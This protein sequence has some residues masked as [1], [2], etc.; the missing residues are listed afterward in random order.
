METETQLRPLLEQ[1]DLQI[2]LIQGDR[3]H[4]DHDDRGDDGSG[5]AFS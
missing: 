5:C 3:D 4:G 2:R 1:D